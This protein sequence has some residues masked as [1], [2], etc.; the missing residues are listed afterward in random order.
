[1]SLLPPF[2]IPAFTLVS[3]LNNSDYLSSLF[4]SITSHAPAL[5]LV[6]QGIFCVPRKPHCPTVRNKQTC[7]SFQRKSRDFKEK[8][9]GYLHTWKPV[10]P[11]YLKKENTVTII[12]RKYKSLFSTESKILARAVRPRAEGVGKIRHKYLEFLFVKPQKLI[13]TWNITVYS[14]MKSFLYYTKLETYKKVKRITSWPPW[15]IS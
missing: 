3:G 12:K 13:L 5:F 14:F 6:C 1:M 10:M 11:W 4:K 15:T 9:C 8:G 7:W 2:S